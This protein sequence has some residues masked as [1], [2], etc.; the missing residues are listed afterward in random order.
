MEH[1]KGIYNCDSLEEYE[2]NSVYVSGSNEY[3]ETSDEDDSDYMNDDY[4]DYEC[5]WTEED[6]WYAL[7]DGMY[8][9]MPDDPR[10]YDRMVDAMG[11]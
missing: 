1:M 6:N 8:G 7:T 2:N 4:D 10:D 3:S 9:D 5:Q 11:F